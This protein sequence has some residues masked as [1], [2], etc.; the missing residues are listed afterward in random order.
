MKQSS[1]FCTGRG[2]HASRAEGLWKMDA[3]LPL[4]NTGDDWQLARASEANVLL[5]GRD[6]E[7]GDAAVYLA[8][9]ASPAVTMW[10][11]T[12]QPMP[13]QAAN[14]VVVA[15]NVDGLGSKEQQELLRWLD[16]AAGQTRVISTA[17]PS[18]WPMVRD[19][20]FSLE[21]YYR[22]NTVCVRLS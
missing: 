16:L 12:V 8:S 6:P 15:R 11:T 4:R 13:R 14:V 9:A 7:L 3:S 19:G 2:S 17:S 18:L 22:L 5:I 1:T 20:A 10:T 21:L